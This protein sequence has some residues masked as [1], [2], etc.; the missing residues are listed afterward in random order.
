MQR[1]GLHQ[2]PLEL[3]RLQQLAQGL[4]L[5]AGIGGVGGLG[6][7]HTQA[8]GVEAHLGDKACCA[9]SGRVD[10]APQR[11][12]VTHQGVGLLGHARLS[13]HPVAQQ[14][15]KARHIQLGQQQPEGRIRRRLG[16]IGAQQLVECLAVPLG[17][18]LHAHQRPLAAQN[19]EDRHQQHPPLGE[20]DAPAHPAVRQRLEKAEQIA[21]GSRVGGGLGGQG[22]G[23]VPAHDTAGT[24]T[25]PG[26]LGQTSNR[27]WEGRGIGLRVA[28]RPGK[29][30]A[31][32]DT[33]EGRMDDLVET[34]KAPIRAKVEHSFRVIKRQFG[35]QKTRLRGML[36][37]R[38][39]VHVL[40][41]LSNLFIARRALLCSM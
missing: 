39:K 36:K 17:E 28:M 20:T 38:C 4:D 9:R 5:A 41:A 1:V 23:A 14:G 35:F 26:L 33:P 15:F 37:N 16:E 8:L 31:L 24:T 19:R 11:L 25:E 12:A 3:H 13:R 29:R 6:D 2:H 34:A 7:R 18:S 32:P 40:A 22:A 10:G 27:P 21:C 30:R